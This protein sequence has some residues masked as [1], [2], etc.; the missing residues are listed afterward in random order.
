MATSHYFNN[1]S[2][3]RRTEQRLYEDLLVESIKIMGHDI[4]YMPRENWDDADTIFGEN[5]HSRFDRAYQME[6]YIANVEGFEG[7][8]DFFTKFGLEIRDNSNFIVAKRTFEKYMPSAITAR[9]RE[10]DLIYVPV[11]HRIFEIKFVEQEL[12]FFTKGNRL[13]YLYELRAE[14]FRYANEKINTGVESIDIADV[15]GSYTLELSVSGSGNYNIGEIVYQGTDLANATATATVSNW[16]PTENKLYVVD[17][18]GE[19][20]N[21]SSIKGASSNTIKSMTTSD[22]LADNVLNDLFDNK[23]IQT[24]VDNFID[25]SEKNPFGSP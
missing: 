5:I 23:Q 19:F 22:P 12:M 20:A 10:G 24:E 4:Y 16:M 14:E 17:I 11:L 2:S 6:M 21:T 18:K 9:P 15:N 25:L 1:F 13:P 3:V 8:G 7:Q